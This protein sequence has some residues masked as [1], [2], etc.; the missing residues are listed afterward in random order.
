MVL[1]PSPGWVFIRSLG[2]GGAVVCRLAYL[3]T[4]THHRVSEDFYPQA[5]NTARFQRCPSTT[6][7]DSQNGQKNSRI[8]LPRLWGTQ[9]D[10]LPA[11]HGMLPQIK[12]WETN[13]QAR[14]PRTSRTGEPLSCAGEKTPAPVPPSQTNLGA[15]L[16]TAAAACPHYSTPQSCRGC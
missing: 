1:V 2:P 5:C 3:Q 15:V 13:P 4:C 7:K 8:F 11:L 9:A 10:R 6:L 16:L 12:D 14:G